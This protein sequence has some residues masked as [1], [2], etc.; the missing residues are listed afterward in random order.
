MYAD[1]FKVYGGRFFTFTRVWPGYLESKSFATKPHASGSTLLGLCSA[2]RCCREPRCTAAG[3]SN[4]FRSVW[5]SPYSSRQARITVRVLGRTRK[6]GAPTYVVI[7][8]QKELTW[9]PQSLEKTPPKTW[10]DKP[11]AYNHSPH[12]HGTSNFMKST[13]WRRQGDSWGIRNGLK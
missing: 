11:R 7:W 5:I 1:V 6:K 12:A 8:P 4:R 13:M 3:S 10:V 9:P 2:A